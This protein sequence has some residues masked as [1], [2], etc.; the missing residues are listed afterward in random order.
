MIDKP[1]YY[2]YLQH[3]QE[4]F[5]YAQENLEVYVFVGGRLSFRVFEPC[6][7]EY[8]FIILSGT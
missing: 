6:R 8:I 5:N 7:H 3:K 2:E 4:I 1:M